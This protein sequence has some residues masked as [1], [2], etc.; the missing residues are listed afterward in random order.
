M[1]REGRHFGRFMVLMNYTGQPIASFKRCFSWQ[2][3]TTGKR[4]GKVVILPGYFALKGAQIWYLALCA[5]LEHENI[6]GA[7]NKLHQMRLS[8]MAAALLRQNCGC[9]NWA[10]GGFRVGDYPVLPGP[11]CFCKKF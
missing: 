4:A 9:L 8:G 2:R 11:L 7:L 3:H 6:R 10:C 1:L 5:S